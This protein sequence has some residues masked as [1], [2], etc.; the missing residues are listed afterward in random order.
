MEFNWPFDVSA[1]AEQER[2]ALIDRQEQVYP[3]S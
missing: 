1:W 2:G 3:I